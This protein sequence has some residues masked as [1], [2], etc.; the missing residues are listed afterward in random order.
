MPPS[1]EPT[2]IVCGHQA[3]HHLPV[4]ETHVSQLPQQSLVG[5]GGQRWGS[6]LRWRHLNCSCL[7]ST[8]QSEPH[9]SLQSI[10]WQRLMFYRGGSWTFVTTYQKRPHMAA[11]A[12]RH[13]ML[14]L[15]GCTSL[16][17]ALGQRL[18]HR[19]C[20]RPRITCS[21]LELQRPDSIP[22]ACCCRQT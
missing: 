19:V 21:H 16:P 13:L 20:Q 2:C 9:L 8:T 1:S 7:P 11:S 14:R 17:C 22:T 4:G 18:C 12:R 3:A 10:L 6:L 15:G 5:P